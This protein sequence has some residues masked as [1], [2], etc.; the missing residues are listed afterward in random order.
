MTDYKTQIRVTALKS[1]EGK[2]IEE[3]ASICNLIE[4]IIENDDKLTPDE[5]LEGYLDDT[6]PKIIHPKKK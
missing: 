1:T 5:I 4:A 3:R 2:S 6:L